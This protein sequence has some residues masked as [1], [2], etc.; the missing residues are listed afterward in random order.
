MNWL[1]LPAIAKAIECHKH[2]ADVAANWPIIK[3][4]LDAVDYSSDP[5]YIAALATT[6]VETAFTFQPIK[7]YGGEK[8]LRS[9]PYYPYF[10][11]GFVQIT[12]DYNYKAYGKLLGIDLLGN[13]DL[14]LESNTAA[15]ILA[16]FFR[17]NHI[18]EAADRQDWVKVRK[19]VN[20]GTNSLPEFLRCVENLQRVVAAC[21]ESSQQS[22]VSFQPDHS[23]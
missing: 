9:K 21:P 15:S 7:E 8:Y 14:A 5:R 19:L 11:R 3:T 23:G 22:A 18:G 4:C 12:W 2:E 20:G 17:D 16:A 6:A 10:G 1:D 13:P